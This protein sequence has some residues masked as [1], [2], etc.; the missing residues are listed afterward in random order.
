MIERSSSCRLPFPSGPRWP[1][2]VPPSSV[3]G[4][5][6]K[7]AVDKRP[8]H[9]LRLIRDVRAFFPRDAISIV[10]GG[11]TA[12]WAHSESVYEPRSYSWAADSATWVLVWPTPSAP[13][14]PGR[15]DGLRDLR[16]RCFGLNIQ[17]LETAAR[18]RLPLVVSSPTTGSGA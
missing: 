5:L 14:W 15:A 2:T 1:S 16:R 6:R 8:I 12:V 7:Q 10:D 17:E 13:S 4:R 18:L 3:A 9:P 11:N